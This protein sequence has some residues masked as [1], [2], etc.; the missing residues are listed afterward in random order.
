[1]NNK[2]KPKTLEDFYKSIEKDNNSIISDIEPVFNEKY[3]VCISVSDFYAKYASLLLISLIQNSSSEHNYDIVIL[4]TDMSHENQFILK[5]LTDKT[6]I[7]I[8][9]FNINENIKNF[10]FY[11]WA[12]FTQNTYY[13]LSIPKLFC[14]YTKVLYLDSD[15]IVNRDVHELFQFDLGENFLAA[16]KD[17]HVMSYCNGLN[18]EQL[19]YNINVLKLEYPKN[20]FQMGVAVF[21]IKAINTKYMKDLLKIATTVEYKWLDQDILNTEFHNKISELPIEWNVM[22]KNKEPYIDEYYLPDEYREKYYEARK[23]PAIIHFCGGVY[24]RFPF[25]PDMKRYFWKFAIQSPYFE[26]ILTQMIAIKMP[27]S[28]LQN[29]ELE[30]LRQEFQKTHFPN[31]NTHF[32]ENERKMLFLFVSNHKFRFI[33]RKT[34][35]KILKHIRFRDWKEKYSK[36][37]AIEDF[38]IKESQNTVSNIY[39]FLNS[40]KISTLK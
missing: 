2:I 33:V 21:N 40:D 13:R 30:C 23:N 26:E 28:E 10:T 3:A 18:T 37:Y 11:T 24:Y 19:E 35:F 38:L 29:K 31:I 25:V 16:V 36:K 7:K 17:T 22:I 5:T 12:H 39:A 14:L 9:I 27:T 15:V 8:R 6:N 32:A 1:M 20:Y 34:C 4:T